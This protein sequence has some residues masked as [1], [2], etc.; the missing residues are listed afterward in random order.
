R[1][2]SGSAPAIPTSPRP[3]RA[4]AIPPR[5]PRR[6]ATVR[7]DGPALVWS[8]MPTRP[9]AS[10]GCS[11]LT[12][13]PAVVDARGLRC[14]LPVLKAEKVLA[15][16]PPGGALTVLATDPMAKIDL[17]LYC[18]QQGHACAVSEA[19]GVLRFEIVKRQSVDAVVI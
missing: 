17:P 13:D 11:S 12:T 7:R 9:T 18:T 6:L 4:G 3:P 14:P 10:I 2:P 16:L 1:S 19:G 15:A 5:M 8:T